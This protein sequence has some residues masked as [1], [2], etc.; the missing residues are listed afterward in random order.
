M[1]GVYVYWP[2]FQQI[3]FTSDMSSVLHQTAMLEA[4]EAIGSGVN[5]VLFQDL[6]RDEIRG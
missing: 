6:R 5:E 1:S 2:S 3:Y 4:I